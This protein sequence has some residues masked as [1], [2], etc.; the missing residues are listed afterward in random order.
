MRNIISDQY[1]KEGD[2][3]WKPTI[4]IN[5]EVFRV[6]RSGLKYCKLTSAVHVSQLV[7]RNTQRKNE[8]I[9]PVIQG[10]DFQELFSIR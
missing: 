3:W 10:R 7:T 9:T 1:P 2:P 5:L 4:S 6:A 8:P